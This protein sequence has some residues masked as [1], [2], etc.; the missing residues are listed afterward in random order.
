[1]CS[2]RYPGPVHVYNDRI[3]LIENLF[4]RTS[5]PKDIHLGGMLCDCGASY[6]ASAFAPGIIA[7]M[8]IAVAV[9]VAVANFRQRKLVLPLICAWV[10]L[11]GYILVREF[12]GVVARLKAIGPGTEAIDEYSRVFLASAPAQLVFDLAL[13]F[14]VPAGITFAVMRR[15][16]ALARR[17]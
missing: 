4:G 10:G 14:M 11:V 6:L 5:F 1:M 15:S 17:G 3:T 2:C 9:W 16:R 13:L 7:L 12:M 8:C